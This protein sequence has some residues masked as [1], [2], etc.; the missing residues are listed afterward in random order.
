MK[1]FPMINVLLQL[2]IALTIGLLEKI[3]VFIYC[4][5]PIGLFMLIMGLRSKN[6]KV[7]ALSTF[8]TDNSEFQH[9][10]PNYILVTID[11]NYYKRQIV[12]K[13]QGVS[14]FLERWAIFLLLIFLGLLSSLII[15]AF[16]LMAHN[17]S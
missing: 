11:P 3:L 10:F 5:L 16:V 12:K 15:A 2:F 8:T 14:N 9:I 17:G 4:L 13:V 7:T 6:H 1:K